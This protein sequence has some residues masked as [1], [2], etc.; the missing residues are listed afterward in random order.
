MRKNLFLFSIIILALGCEGPEGP[1]G[2][3]GPSGVTMI[4]EYTGICDTSVFIFVDIPEIKNRQ[5][6]TFVMAYWAF[7]DSPDLWTP[8]SDGWWDTEGSQLLIVSWTEGGVLL[9]DMLEGLHYLI[10][11]FEHQ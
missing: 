6:S 2:P 9:Y 11:V 3:Q 5:T 10:Q 8:I 1:I 4:S 7:P